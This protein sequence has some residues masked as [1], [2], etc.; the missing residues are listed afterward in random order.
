VSILFFSTQQ[1]LSKVMMQWLEV[2]SR[3]CRGRH[4]AFESWLVAEHFKHGFS[5]GS[6]VFL[7]TA[8]FEQ[9]YDAMA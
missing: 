7:Y 6:F 1:V 3:V 2:V 8:G 9:S 5:G 4:A